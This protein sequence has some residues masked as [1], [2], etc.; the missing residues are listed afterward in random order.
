M[1]AGFMGNQTKRMG[2]ALPQKSLLPQNFA[3]CLKS[4]VN[5]SS[6]RESRSMT[7]KPKDIHAKTA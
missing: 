3:A 1:R 2:A 6:S 4:Q 5:R 7:F